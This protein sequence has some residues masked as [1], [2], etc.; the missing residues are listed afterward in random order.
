MTKWKLSLNLFMPLIHVFDVL[1]IS[2]KF[3]RQFSKVS[4][5]IMNIA[6]AIL[7][8]MFTMSI[9]FHILTS[10]QEKHL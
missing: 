10:T 7:F 5:F 9:K 4:I 8:W 2:Y 6:L 1:V 3:P